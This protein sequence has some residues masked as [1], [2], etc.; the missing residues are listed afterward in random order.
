MID[1][2][3][4]DDCIAVQDKALPGRRTVCSHDQRRVYSC[5][6][7][8]CAAGNPASTP[9]LETRAICAPTAESNDPVQLYCPPGELH[10]PVTCCYDGVSC[11]LGGIY[12]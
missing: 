2:F 1:R 6:D 5:K 9:R 10:L 7:K 12:H 3:C 4:F 11:T 8:T